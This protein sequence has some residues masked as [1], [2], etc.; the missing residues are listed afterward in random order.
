[1][2]IS[3]NQARMAADALN[4][5]IKSAEAKGSDSIGLDDV[6]IGVDDAA[7]AVLQAAIEAAQKADANKSAG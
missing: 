7:R 5:A 1:M 2:N 4:G 6:L 3:I